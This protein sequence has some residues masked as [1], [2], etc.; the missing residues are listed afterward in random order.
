MKVVFGAM[1]AKETF[2]LEP[3]PM[4]TKQNVECVISFVWKNRALVRFS[5]HITSSMLPLQIWDVPP[6]FPI[7]QLDV[8]LSHFSAIVFVLDF[9]VKTPRVTYPPV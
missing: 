4:I 7:N 9:Q 6:S 8:P 2:Y 1:T 5:I 3:S